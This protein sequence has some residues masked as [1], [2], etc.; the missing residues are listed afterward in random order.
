MFKLNNIQA[1]AIINKLSRES[2]KLRNTLIEEEI[3][4]YVPSKEYQELTALLD[5]RDELKKEY[6]KSMTECK[7]LADKLGLISFYASTTRAEDA[8]PR[9]TK[10]EVSAKYP[11]ID[12][13]AALDD[14]I[15]ESVKD[16]FDIDNFI[17][18]YLKKI[19]NE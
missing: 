16:E 19:K 9:L 1:K 14:L 7:E 5:K 3:K 12:L 15:I 18:T 10:Q 6:E 17:N 4:N 11:E 13:D 8:I 2:S